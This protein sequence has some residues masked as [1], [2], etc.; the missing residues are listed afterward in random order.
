MIFGTWSLQETFS[1]ERSNLVYAPSIIFSVDLLSDQVSQLY[2]SMFS[3][4]AVNIRILRLRLR[5]DFHIL[6]SLLQAVQAW[7]FLHFMS[8]S[9][10][11]AYDP[12]YL[13]SLTNLIFSPDWDMISLQ[14]GCKSVLP[15]S[16][17]L[18]RSVLAISTFFSSCWALLIMFAVSA[19]SSAK[20]RSLTLIS[21][22]QP[23]FVHEI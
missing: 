3:T 19:I 18:F 14:L 11:L 12:S 7:A 23:D 22:I 16:S 10:S 2:R 4:V 6:E 20:S 5:L 8:F 13:K 15:F 9:E 17:V 21:G 1:A